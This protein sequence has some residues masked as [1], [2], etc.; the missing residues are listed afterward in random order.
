MNTNV[1]RF[2]L[3]HNILTY[4]K[5]EERKNGEYSIVY[6]LTFNVHFCQIALKQDMNIIIDI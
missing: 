5:R 6:R 2:S 1:H 4:S 3:C